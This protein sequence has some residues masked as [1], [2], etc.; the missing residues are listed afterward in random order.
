MG[1]TATSISRNEEDLLR[2]VM[3]FMVLHAHTVK[4]FV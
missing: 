4:D 3:L 2:F 1:H